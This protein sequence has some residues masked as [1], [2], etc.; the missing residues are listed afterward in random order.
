ME[1]GAAA[2]TSASSSKGTDAGESHTDVGQHPRYIQFPRTRLIVVLWR[3][4]ISILYK[5]KCVEFRSSKQVIRY[6]S[7]MLLLFALGAGH[8][9]KGHNELITA[10]VLKIETLDVEIALKKYSFAAE[11]ADLTGLAA[12]WGV[13][14]VRCIVLDKHSIRLARE[15]VNLSKGCLGMVRQFALKTVVPHFC[16]K[17]DLGKFIRVPLPRGKIVV[18]QLCVPLSL[19]RNSHLDNS[20]ISDIRCGDALE[21]RLATQRGMFPPVE[22]SPT[23][24]DSDCSFSCRHRTRP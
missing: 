19:N 4:W 22:L 12:K 21:L 7:G 17:D 5:S 24:H 8:R 18:R 2:G 20:D 13:T 15:I 11:Q 14:E 10:R 3:F 6:E 16:H 9:R 23:S 1:A